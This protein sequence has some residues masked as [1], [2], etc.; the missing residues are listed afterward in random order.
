MNSK[1]ITYF[2]VLF[3]LFFSACKEE[4]CEDVICANGIPLQDG[5]ECI[6][7]CDRGW[8]GD[9]CDREDPCQT[10]TIN[11][12]NGGTC[13]NGNCLCDVG[14]EGDT[15]EILVRDYFIGNYSAAL[16]CPPDVQNINFSIQAPDSLVNDATEL[17]IFNLTNQAYLFDGRVNEQGIVLIPQQSI[18]SGTV[19]IDGT[20]RK[21]IEGFT[22]E[23]QKTDSVG[24]Q[25]CTINIVK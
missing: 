4:P 19:I 6:C 21:T 13:V 5:Y 9:N 7:L 1:Y 10:Q 25:F 8:F 3:L 14:F 2:S 23:F 12:Y 16:E 15:C 22:I 20:I 24:S 11:C 18:Q 17:V